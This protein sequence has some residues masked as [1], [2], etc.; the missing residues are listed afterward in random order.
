MPRMIELEEVRRLIE[1]GAQVVDVLSR[2]EYEESHLPGAIHLP[3]TE[4]DTQAAASLDR[5]RAVIAYCYD[6]E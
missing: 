3:L 4:L 6:Y 1:R 2:K 5:D